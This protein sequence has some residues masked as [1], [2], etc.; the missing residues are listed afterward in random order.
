MEAFEDSEDSLAVG[1]VEADA[2]VSHVVGWH[3]A[4]VPV[5]TQFDERAIAR[6]GVLPTNSGAGS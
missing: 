3:V 1:D 5:D 4:L 2:V 6:S